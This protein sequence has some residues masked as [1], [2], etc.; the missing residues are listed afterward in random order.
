MLETLLSSIKNLE[1]YFKATL[2]KFKKKIFT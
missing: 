2:N 1:I